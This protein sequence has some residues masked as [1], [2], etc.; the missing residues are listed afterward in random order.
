MAL[1]NNSQEVAKVESATRLS[2]RTEGKST[3]T[4][5]AAGWGQMNLKTAVIVGRL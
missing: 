1:T 2:G 4:A 5:E 3:Q